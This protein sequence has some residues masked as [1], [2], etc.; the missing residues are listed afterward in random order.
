MSGKGTQ[1]TRKASNNQKVTW[2]QAFRDVTIASMNR[3]QLP[4]LALIAF[5]MLMVVRMPSEDVSKLVFSVMEKLAN[6]EM[7]AYV[8]LVVVTGA[9]F[10]HARKMRQA[11]TAEMERAGR[12]KS[13]LQGA[14]SGE[15]YKS[16]NAS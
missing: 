7:V 3:G 10:F 11:F 14:V 8:L 5:V 12:E 2:A 4:V 13:R 15:Q 9:W 16:S 6:G 1:K